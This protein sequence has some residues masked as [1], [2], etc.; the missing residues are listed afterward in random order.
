MLVAS[1]NVTAEEITVVE[2]FNELGSAGSGIKECVLKKQN[3]SLNNFLMLQVESLQEF[4]GRC[5]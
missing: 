5:D 3:V 2:H 1:P 4:N